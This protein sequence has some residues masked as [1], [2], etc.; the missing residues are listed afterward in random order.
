MHNQLG[1]TPA[2]DTSTRFFFDR[3]FQVLGSGRFATALLETITDP[4]LKGLPLTGAVDEFIDSTDAVGDLGF[5]RA[6]A[7]AGIRGGSA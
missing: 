2:L 1:L 3:P 5:L 6:C 4:R 7:A